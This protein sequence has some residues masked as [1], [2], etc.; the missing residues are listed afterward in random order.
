MMMDEEFKRLAQE[1][2]KKID[3][4]LRSSIKKDFV[5]LGRSVGLGADG[6]TTKYIDKIAEDVAIKTIK[7]SGDSVNLLSE[8]VGFIDNHAKY[9]FILDPV[10]GTRNAFRGIP[11]FSVSLAIGKKSL[12]DV[13]YGIVKNVSTGDVFLAEKQHGAYLNNNRIIIPNVFAPEPLV[14]V[15]IGKNKGLVPEEILKDHVIR[16]YGSAS[17]E[18]CLVA[19]GGLDGYVVHRPYLRVTDIAAATLVVRESGGFVSDSWGKPL[20][21]PLNLDER[22]GVIAAGNK[23]FIEK[24]RR[25]D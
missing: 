11:F 10:D 24:V 13:S 3:R 5:K 9:T 19:I 23:D 2:V 4:K 16:C 7:K 12:H 20:N 1:I 8:E 15:S 25:I 6:T 17:L 21:M 22:C 18:M 14:S